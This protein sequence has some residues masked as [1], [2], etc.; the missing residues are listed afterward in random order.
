MRERFF[1]SVLTAIFKRTLSKL[2]YGPDDCYNECILFVALFWL[3][4]DVASAEALA[5]PAAEAM[6]T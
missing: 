2:A 5:P 6:A 4:T 3:L 1:Y